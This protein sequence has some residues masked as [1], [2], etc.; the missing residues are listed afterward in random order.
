MPRAEPKDDQWRD[1]ATINRRTRTLD[2][3]AATL[4]ALLAPA[5]DGDEDLGPGREPPR[6]AL[7][8]TTDDGTQYTGDVI[9]EAEEG[10]D[11]HPATSRLAI[12]ARTDGGEQSISL[13]LAQP[14]VGALTE[15][16]AVAGDHPPQAS[17]AS[18]SGTLDGVGYRG[19]AGAATIAFDADRLTGRF[20]LDL[21]GGA[22]AQDG[23]PP[24]TL[25]GTFEATEIVL[26][27]WRVVTP[28]P[29]DNAPGQSDDDATPTRTLDSVDASPFC[30]AIADGLRDVVP[31]YP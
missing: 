24:L 19:L 17:D 21:I 20:D 3:A 6:I 7:T 18:I 29:G 27:C 22:R 10:T 25:S 14:V 30:A 5:C 12:R 2:L 15:R 16:Y 13:T 31:L 26:S 4:V 28:E 23:A 11:G 1:H 9:Y 8:L